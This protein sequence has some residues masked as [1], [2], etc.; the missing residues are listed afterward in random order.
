MNK[1]VVNGRASICQWELQLMFRSRDQT[2]SFI[3]LLLKD[4][5]DY[6]FSFVKELDETSEFYVL[7]VVGKWANNLARVSR[8]A[9]QVDYRLSLE[10]DYEN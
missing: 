8:L 5:V 2:Q 10:E 3:T 7:T 1:P 4:E 9:E 6:D